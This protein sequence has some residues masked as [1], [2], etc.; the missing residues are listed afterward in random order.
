MSTSTHLITADELMRMSDDGHRYELVKGE[1]L[2]MS[3]PGY[4]H[5]EI[6]MTLGSALKQF[7]KQLQLGR[8]AGG[9][10][11]FKLESDPD[12][13]LAPD[14]SFI[15]AGRLTTR[16]RDYARIVPDLVVEVISPGDRKGKVTE[17]AKLWLSFGVQSVWLVRPNNRTVEIL[18]QDGAT[19]ILDETE[20]LSD[21]VVPG[22]EIPVSVIFE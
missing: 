2:T 19:R 6:L 15:R 3:P 18:R 9:D 16:P 12:T 20:V 13:V 11:G 14:I 10:A 17:K 5:G 8:V 22:F 7:I 21:T 1:L 4:E